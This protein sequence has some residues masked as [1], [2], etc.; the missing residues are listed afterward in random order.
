MTFFADLGDFHNCGF[1]ES[2]PSADRNTHSVDTGCG[3]IFGKIPEGN[4][5]PLAAGFI[6]AFGCQKTD[7]AVPFPGMGISLQ[8]MIL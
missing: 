3:N 1:P 8:S 6:D 2:N 4:I 5:Q 7:L